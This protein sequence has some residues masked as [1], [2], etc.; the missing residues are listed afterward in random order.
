MQRRFLFLLGLLLWTS[1]AFAQATP[2]ELV[3]YP[4][5]IF[6]NG[7]IITVDERASVAQAVAV[8]D[9]KIL[10]VGQ[11]AQILKLAGPKTTRIDLKGKTMLPGLVDTHSHLQEYALDHW[12]EDHPLLKY[13]KVGAERRRPGGNAKARTANE[14]SQ[15]KYISRTFKRRRVAGGESQAGRMAH[16]P[17]GANRRGQ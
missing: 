17:S 4:D 8:R 12:G 7:K 11:N 1:R 5:H 6:L 16:D 14:N 2:A 15:W 13:T 9:G 10:A 3:H